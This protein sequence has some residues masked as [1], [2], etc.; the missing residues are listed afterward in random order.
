MNRV[1]PK[2]VLRKY[3]VQTAIEK[4]QLEDF[5]EIDQLHSLLQNPYS[6]QPDMDAYAAHLPNRGKH[7]SA[8]CPS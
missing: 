7:L 1:D 8:G 3:L 6:D 4:A 5:S 2:Y